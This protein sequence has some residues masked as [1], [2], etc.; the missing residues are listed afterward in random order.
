MSKP[1][2]EVHSIT[3]Y[4]IMPATTSSGAHLTTSYSVL[5]SLYCFREVARFAKPDGRGGNYSEE[6][7]RA[8]AEELCL[9]LNAE[10]RADA[11]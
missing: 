2:Y 10:D 7:F 11:A 4:A 1:R 9:R 8:Q 6:K 5:D 3:G